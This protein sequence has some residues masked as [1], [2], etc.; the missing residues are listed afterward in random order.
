MEEGRSVLCISE[1]WSIA[2][3]RL[4]KIGLW[5]GIFF[6]HRSV[7]FLRLS[8][9]IRQAAAETEAILPLGF[10]DDQGLVGELAVRAP[11]TL[12]FPL[13]SGSFS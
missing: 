2:Q 5:F 7:V 9:G 13:S 1:R 6:G 11:C 12:Q 10:L 8:D 4:L 3:A